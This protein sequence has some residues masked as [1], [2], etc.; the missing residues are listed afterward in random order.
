MLDGHFFLVVCIATISLS[1]SLPMFF[2]SS[3]VLVNSRCNEDEIGR[4]GLGRKKGTTNT[5]TL[6]ERS[7]TTRRVVV[8]GN[9]K[10]KEDARGRERERDR[11]KRQIQR[12]VGEGKN[13]G[14]SLERNTTR[15]KDTQ[16][17]A[18]GCLSR[19]TERKLK[20]RGP[21]VVKRRECKG[22]GLALKYVSPEATWTPRY[23]VAGASGKYA[24]VYRM[25]QKHHIIFSLRGRSE[26]ARERTSLGACDHHYTSHS[27]P[28]LHLLPPPSMSLTPSPFY[29]FVYITRITDYASVERIH[30][31]LLQDHQKNKINN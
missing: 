16:G 29:L 26:R 17:Q 13:H 11:K 18:K 6:F 14:P 3:H 28:F 31:D 19:E 10:G 30:V 25:I 4:K 15:F 21:R 24:S 22:K 23:I 1:L 5:G 7:F 27:P 8:R 12:E 9:C 2:R 20:R